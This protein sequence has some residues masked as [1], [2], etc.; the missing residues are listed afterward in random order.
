MTQSSQ[1][2]SLFTIDNVIT[3]N[4]EIQQFYEESIKLFTFKT[5]KPNRLI[6]PQKLLRY[7][8]FK[9]VIVKNKFN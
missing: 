9:L 7:V 2:L 6:Q 4:S 3:P 5:S 1:I 8:S